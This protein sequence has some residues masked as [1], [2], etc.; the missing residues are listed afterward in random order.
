MLVSEMSYRVLIEEQK[1]LQKDDFSNIPVLTHLLNSGYYASQILAIRRLFDQAPKGD[2]LSL[3]R[4]LNDIKKHQY[5]F[6]REIFVSFDGTPYDPVPP[7]SIVPGLQPQDSPFSMFIRSKHRHERFDL[8]SK[9]SFDKS[10]RFDR[11][12]IDIFNRLD[13]WLNAS[14][15]QRLV[16][17]SHKYIAHA[18]DQHSRRKIKIT[19]LDFAEVESVQKVIVRVSRAIFDIILNS[20]V[21]S[22]VVP[23]IP[24]D[25]FGKGWDGKAIVLST[26]RM[27]KQWD[28]LASDRNSWPNNLEIDLCN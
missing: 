4:V 12:H 9:V 11:I 24:L 5:L 15:A 18:A 22:Q 26:A 7:E 17:L 28:E 14:G 2:V 6:T 8:L 16:K 27:K 3:S 20:G 13:D 10:S 23:M 19:G 25:F 1:L 21:H